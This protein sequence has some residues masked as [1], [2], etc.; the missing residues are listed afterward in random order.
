MKVFFVFFL[1]FSL[2]L[3]AQDEI[4]L[5]NS[6]GEATAYIDTG[7][8]DL[9]IYL[10]AG[11]PVAYLYSKSGEFHVYGFNGQHLGWLIDGILRDHEGQV[12][13][14]TKDAINMLT[15]LEPLKGFKEAKP[16]KNFKENIPYKPYLENFW[17]SKNLKLFLLRGIDN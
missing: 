2:S 12:V 15:Q 7:D 9:T 8:K 6:D 13:A 17:S 16:F 1:F 14:S 4:A 11:A 5:Y 3:S 10:W